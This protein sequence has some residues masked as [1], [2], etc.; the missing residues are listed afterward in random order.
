[1]CLNSH[2]LKD[3]YVMDK[4]MFCCSVFFFL[5]HLV[6]ILSSTWDYNFCFTKSTLDCQLCS[7]TH[8][9]IWKFGHIL[10]VV[11]PKPQQ[12]TVLTICLVQSLVIIIIL[13]IITNP[14][15]NPN[16]PCFNHR[17]ISRQWTFLSTT[18]LTLKCQNKLIMGC[19]LFLECVTVYIYTGWDAHSVASYRTYQ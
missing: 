5:T 13:I 8:F 4:H 12:P 16:F 18:F 19:D 1:M 15:P 6:D 10:K 17:M 14:H 9:R 2:I 3:Q 11:F 7:L